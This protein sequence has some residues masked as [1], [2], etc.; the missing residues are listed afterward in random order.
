MR[1]TYYPRPELTV[2]EISICPG[3]PTNI[4]NLLESPADDISPLTGYDLVAAKVKT[5]V[6]QGG[7]YPPIHGWG[8]ATFNWACGSGKRSS[9]I[10]L[11]QDVIP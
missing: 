3:F 9:R 11:N 7:W 10:P 8:A 1:V 4:R 2:D 5:V 6:W